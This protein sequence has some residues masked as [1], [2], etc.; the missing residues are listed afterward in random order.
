MWRGE[1]ISTAQLVVRN[2]ISQHA[3]IRFAERGI[4]EKMT[5]TAISKGQKYYDVKNNAYSYVLEGGFAS[6][7][8]LQV[9]TSAIDGRVTT[10]IRSTR[11]NPGVK[12]PDGSVR[13]IPIE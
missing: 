8:T 4:T 11:F 13:F 10:V 6:G 9:G 2:P 7:K 3:A 5:Q 1:D 12:L